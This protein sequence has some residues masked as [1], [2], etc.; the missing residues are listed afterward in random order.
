L[1]EE[2]GVVDQKYLGFQC[3][4][5]SQEFEPARVR[6]VC[7]SCGGNLQI[8]YDYKKIRR[9][10][11][12]QAL[13]KNPI[14]S[15]WRY[16]DIL[17]VSGSSG[18]SPLQIGWTP[19]YPSVQG[20]LGDKLGLKRLFFKDD[21]RNP[22]ASF[23][24]RAGAIAVARAF[25]VGENLITGASTGNAASSLACV[26]VPLGMKTIIFVPQT[27]PQAKIAQLLVFG[28]TVVAVKGTYDQAFDL[29]LEA[30]QAY[31]W[32]N[33]N[34]GYNPFT[35][36]GKKT[37]SFE[38]AEQLDWA[39]PDFV[40]VPVGDGNIISGVWKGFKDLHALGL[41]DRLPKLL[42]VQGGESDSVKR[43]FEGNG[44]IEAVSG[45][46]IADSISVSIPRDGEAAVQA[47]RES[48]GLAIGVSDAEILT[49][50]RRLA[51]EEGVFAEPA[52]AAAV[53]GLLQAQARGVFR[54]EDKIVTL[55]TGNG[56]KD[57][58]SAM[59]AVGQPFSISPT[60]DD[61]RQLMLRLGL[62]SATK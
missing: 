25:D 24:D 54:T 4:H 22:S 37:C 49:G 56:L 29:C 43:A 10:L 20:G 33:R 13:A 58:A 46:T 8:T 17:P 36:E 48:G 60:M 34:T 47:L 39:V 38:I 41:I 40:I 9:V 31:G 7:S 12:K 45:A 14:T 61:L 51:R 5:C 16:L 59:K 2:N 30:T 57:V 53:A 27:A 32:Y 28:A 52:A 3:I 35:R 6:Y 21:G 42:G 62:D 26:S 44:K 19:L 50:M 1:R 11:T 55:I 15:I 23:K 18:L